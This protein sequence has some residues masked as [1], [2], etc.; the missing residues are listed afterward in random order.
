MQKKTET[1]LSKNQNV[2]ESEYF[3]PYHYIPERDADGFSQT[4]YWSWGMRYMAGIELVLSVL[5]E[6]VFKSVLDVGCGDGRFL[7]E[8]LNFC[9]DATCLGID[10][11]DKAIAFAKAFNPQIDYV[12]LDITTTRLDR[13]FDIITMGEVLEHI[14]PEQ[15]PLFLKSV[16]NLLTPNGKLILTVPH[17]NKRVQAKH[18]QHFSS[19]SLRLAMEPF[20]TVERV[21]PFDR[22]SRITGWMSRVLGHNG[23]NYI[24]T[25]RKLNLLLYKRILGGCLN[26]QPEDRCGR[27]LAIAKKL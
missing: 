4:L 10:Y 25:N 22:M 3:I 5:K 1:K 12:C 6:N 13:Q 16:A 21:M 23:N 14:P 18:Y 24:V 11:S 19:T 26:E 20:F 17:A 2:Q 8:V 9:P 27:L 7:R 15:V